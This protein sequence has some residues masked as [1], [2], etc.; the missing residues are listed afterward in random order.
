[1]ESKLS[2]AIAK[3]ETQQTEAF[4]KELIDVTN[5]L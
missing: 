2:E 3:L 1:L 5:K 4:E